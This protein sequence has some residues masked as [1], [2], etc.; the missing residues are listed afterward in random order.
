VHKCNK[1]RFRRDA[2]PLFCNLDIKI[3]SIW[4][5]LP[6]KWED[7]QKSHYIRSM[8][9]FRGPVNILILCIM[10]IHT[11]YVYTQSKVFLSDSS[12]HMHTLAH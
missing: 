7:M 8:S 3:D 12:L 9:F 4:T 5:T 11:L 10:L 2:D 6:L 1:I